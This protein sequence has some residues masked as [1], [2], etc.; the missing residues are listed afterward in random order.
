LA[1]ARDKQTTAPRIVAVSPDDGS[2]IDLKNPL[3]AA[4]LAWAVPGL[5]HLYQGR[6]FKGRLFMGAI[7]GTFL[8]GMWLG[9][10]KVVYAS[11][12]PGDTRWPFVCQAGAG[13]VALPAVVQSLQLHGVA[14]QPFLASTFMAPPLVAGQ[15]VSRRYAERLAASD[16][17]IDAEDFFDR[18]PLKQFRGEQV[19]HWQRRLGRWFDIGT[20]YTMLAGMLNVLVIYDAWAGPLG[21]PTDAD[22]KARPT[23]KT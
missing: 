7:L 14:K 2:A 10:G 1:L 21:T 4:A 22:R 11:W 19:S 16:P 15:Y 3:L 12:K 20:L 9:G 18:P 17:D 5:G 13:L 8:A 23:P 6:L